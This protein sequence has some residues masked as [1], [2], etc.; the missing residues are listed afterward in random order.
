MN[1]SVYYLFLINCINQKNY[2][3]SENNAATST[4]PTRPPTLK[5]TPKQDVW[6]IRQDIG[7]KIGASASK[8][9]MPA[10]KQPAG[11]AAKQPVGVA[12]A[13]KDIWQT[14]TIQLHR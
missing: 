7:C 14:K 13:R 5:R 2:R 8:K 10:S 4:T 6:Q 12:T 3:N 1:V 11:V 9:A